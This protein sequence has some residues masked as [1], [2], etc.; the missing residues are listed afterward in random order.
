MARA[1]PDMTPQAASNTMWGYATLGHSPAK[2]ALAALETAAAKLGPSMNLHDVAN[3][4]WSYVT[5]EL[6]PA[7]DTRWSCTR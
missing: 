3:L 6:Q 2:G 5:L 1:A 4:W 7:V